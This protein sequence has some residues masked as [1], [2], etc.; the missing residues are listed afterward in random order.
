MKQ[1][2][3]QL[4]KVVRTLPSISL[5]GLKGRANL[6]DRRDNKYILTTDEV[7]RFLN[8]IAPQYKILEID[9]ARQFHY[10]S[11]YYDT[12][13]FKTHRDHNK[14]RRRRIKVRHRHYVDSGLHYFEIKLKGFR[15]LTQK[16]RLP[17]DPKQL[18]EGG[19]SGELGHFFRETLTEEYGEAYGDEW[20]STLHP[21]I[22][23]GYHRITLVARHDHKRITLD[24]GIYFI[25]EADPERR[26]VPLNPRYWIVEVKSTTGRTPLDRWLIRR[27][28]RPVSA[29][30]K[31]GMGITLL[32]QPHKNSR[33]RQT[34]RRHFN[35]DL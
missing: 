3:N 28:R 32:K 15:Q 10:L 19:I 30:S 26:R 4:A 35:Y 34:L 9:G 25:D 16:F 13:H 33:F 11:T 24:N 21:S 5:S 14:G 6:M 20:F 17:I 12:P 1:Q 27:G 23:V 22:S 18:K 2:R 8:H 31:Y 7:V 29:C